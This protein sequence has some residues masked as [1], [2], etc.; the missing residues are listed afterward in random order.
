[1]AVY[2]LHL[3]VSWCTDHELQHA[4]FLNQYKEN[5]Y[6]SRYSDWL[7]AGRSQG[8]SSSPGDDKNFHFSMS[9]KPALGPTP[10]SYLMG[11]GDSFPG[12]KA[13]RAWNW[14]LTSN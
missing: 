14:P 11:T 13:A 10:A 4:K 5:G 6:I 1:M 8:Q 9:S 7:R 3:A 12:K 2:L